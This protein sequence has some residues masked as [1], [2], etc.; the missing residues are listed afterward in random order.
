MTIALV[1][2][3]A[4]LLGRET[5][6]SLLDA[7]YEVH[8]L[9]RHQ[10]QA[11]HRDIT[12]HEVDLG[13]P[14]DL[15]SL[16]AGVRHVFHLAQSREYRDFPGSS[17]AVF[18]VNVASTAQLLD[19]AYRANVESFVYA[20]SGGVYDTS[21][22][23]VLTEATSVQRPSQLGY[24]LGTKLACEALAGSYSSL[25]VVS[26][27]RYFF[28]YGPGQS[29]SM[30]IPRLYDRVREGASLGLTGVN[31]MRLNPVHVSDAAQATIAA[32]RLDESAT[33]NVAGP[34]VLSLRELGVLFGHDLG[35]EPVFEMTDGPSS[36]FVASTD[37]M[38]DLLTAPVRTVAGSLADI[39]E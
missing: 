20:S 35:R 9:V 22:S 16:P 34:E 37:M 7:G 36:D 28:I 19:Y 1:T 18:S 8:A 2:G 13:K 31:G 12:F 11:F 24:Y 32:A 6:L 3:A 21:A 30:L 26:S 38:R 14:L 25:F 4:G 33:V 27:I 29:R 5:A 10:S 39:R 17:L 15:R 23:G